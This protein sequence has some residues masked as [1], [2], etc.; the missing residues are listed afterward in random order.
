MFQLSQRRELNMPTSAQSLD[1][2]YNEELRD[3]WSANNQM[4]AIVAHFG[5]EAVD[6]KLK[7][8]L[9]KAAKGI[10]DHTAKLKSLLDTAGGSGIDHC[11]GMGGL[12]REAKAHVVDGASGDERLN[13]LVI[14]AQ[15]QRMSHY[16]LAG[17]G[18]AA[19]YA[20]A[21]N[22]TADEQVL[23]SIVSDIYRGDEIASRLA[24]RLEAGA[25]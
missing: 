19:A 22:R 6:A 24:E 18:T 9:Q 5:R 23:K 21:L 14:V 20:K 12:V 8:T 11:R 25:A 15:Y 4:Q 13:D 2:L 3:L 7:D 10:A 17:F 16:G 1:D